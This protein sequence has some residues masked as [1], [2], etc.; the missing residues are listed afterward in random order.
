MASLKLPVQILNATSNVEISAAPASLSLS[1]D[2]SDIPYI[3]DGDNS[4]RT[5]PTIPLRQS[6]S[7]SQTNQLVKKCAFPLTKLKS[8][9]KPQQ[10][11]LTTTANNQSIEMMQSGQDMHFPNKQTVVDGKIKKDASRSIFDIR[12]D[13]SNNI[14]KSV[15]Q[16]ELGGSSMLMKPRT[17]ETATMYSTEPKLTASIT[18]IGG[19]V[20]R[21]KTAE[22]ERMLIQQ[23][24]RNSKSNSID[25]S[26]NRRDMKPLSASSSTSSSSTQHSKK[27]SDTLSTTIN[28][29]KNDPNVRNGPIYK[30][31]DV[32][33]SALNLKK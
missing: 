24:K 23:N 33:S 8:Q 26:A 4:F 18:S 2:L 16:S 11:Q 29:N 7:A 25:S 6:K 12:K 21:S 19:D 10:V 31:R 27:A 13:A 9:Y 22:F 1:S 15:S 17:V 5:A 20:M 32:I 14:E 28:S 30:R 3:E